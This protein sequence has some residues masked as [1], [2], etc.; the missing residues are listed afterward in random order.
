MPVFPNYLAGR[1][2]ALSEQQQAQQNLL[3]QQRMG[4]ETQ[5]VNI[6]QQNADL[7][8]RNSDILNQGRMDQQAAAKTAEN[9]AWAQNA[10]NFAKKAPDQIPAVIA[11]AKRRGILH[12]DFP[13]AI[14]PEQLDQ[15]AIEQ[16]LVSP[17][18]LERVDGPRGSVLQ[19][20]PTTGELKQVVGPDNS[21]PVAG[22]FRTLTPQEVAAAG[23]PAGTSAQRDTVTGKVDVLSKRD[24]TGVLSQKDATTA[25]MKLNTVA[26]ARQQLQKI[27]ESFDE[28]RQGI[29][30]FGPGQGFLPT[31]AGKKF[32][33]RVDQMRSTL[34][35]LTRVPGVGSMSDYETKLDQSKFPN[36]RAYESVTADVLNNLD[37]Q[38]SL[39]EN[40]YRG[41]LEGNTTPPGAPSKGGW[42][43]EVVR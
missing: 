2:A 37:D 4:L 40:G 30:A 38:L 14:S 11:A 35:A 25:K 27:R 17:T 19:R 39:I 6:A 43:V 29:N 24:N 1:N 8:Q 13:D 34:T 22:Q 33:A 21:Q 23:L 31:Q 36:R 42:S 3:A 12:A 28:G 16:G 41:L 10:Y 9:K 7:N 20:D 15:F 5:N 32:D 26:L 18:Q